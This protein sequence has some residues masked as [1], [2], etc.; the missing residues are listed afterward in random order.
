M[1]LSRIRSAFVLIACSAGFLHADVVTLKDGRKLEGNILSESAD[2]IRMR[3][4]LTPKIWDEKD[5]QR[6]EIAEGGIL[7]QKPEEVELIELKKLVPTVDLLTA[8]KYEQII[9]DRLRPFI[10][11]YPKTPEAAEAEKM[12]AVM[13]EEKEKVVAGGIKLEGK[14]LNPDETKAESLN[15]KAYGLRAAMM[16]KA[17][18]KDYSGALKEFD[19]LSDPRSGY[20]ASIYYPKAVE[21]AVALLTKYEAQVE[22]MIKDQPTLLKMREDG[23]KKLI[24]PDLTRMKD[25]VKREEE[26]WKTNY[27]QERK[28]SRWYTPYKYDMPS[29]KTLSQSII[30]EKNR[31]KDIDIPVITKVNEAIARL[32]RADAKAAQNADELKKMGEAILEGE[33][34][35][36]SADSNSMQFYQ[37]VFQAY[38]Q[39]YA[40]AEQQLAVATAQQQ[41]PAPAAG[42]VATGSSAIAGTGAAPGE[43]AKMAAA[44][45]AAAAGNTAAPN[46][47]AAAPGMPA[48]GTTDPNAA[49]VPGAVPNGYPAQPGAMPAP[50]TVPNG[51][52]QQQPGYAPQQQGYAQP[53]QPVASAPMPV[54]PPEEEGM[55]TTNMLLIGI[56]VVVLVL[57]LTLLGGGKKKQK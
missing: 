1:K 11:R 26:L 50:G 25:A 15:I 6:S 8:E 48:Q 10:N 23:I 37:N 53:Q 17:E 43:D 47:N 44:L 16:E 5:I 28:S 46:P 4:K 9:Q 20:I 3:Y 14:W 7:K 49:Q 42:G 45:A 12:L 38:R 51:Y 2:A 22:Q 18:A 55:S 56:G 31:L 30:T 32:M 57:L 29:L 21:E 19:K 35:A 36:A 13:Q 27:D 39:R 24:E 41:M 33:T 34:A 40:Y 52:P 54:T